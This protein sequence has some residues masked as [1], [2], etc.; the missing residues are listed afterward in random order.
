MHELKWRYVLQLLGL[1]WILPF[2]SYLNP[3]GE[4]MMIDVGQGDCFL[5]QL[6][7]HQGTMMIDVAGSLYKNIPETVIAPILKAKGIRSIDVLVVSH[8]DYDHSGGLNELSDLV[9][10][11]QVITD[12]QPEIALGPARFSI[13]QAMDITDDRNDQS[14]IVYG[15]LGRHDYL[16][17]GDAGVRVEEYLLSN[18]PLLT[19]DVLKLGH[20]GS[21]TSS[22]AAF[23]QQVS[24]QL[25][26]I[27]AGKNNRYHHPSDEVIKR[28][29][30][31][32]IA[33]QNS[34]ET[35]AVSIYVTP[36]FSFFVNASHEFGFL[37]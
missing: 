15:T 7:F 8:D 29:N 12:Y 14:L 23:L 35:G 28:L 32:Q 21:N 25:A 33:Y 20:H 6:P 9:S 26:L 31:Y 13:L 27:S 11:D 3:F 5:I 16:F 1:L 24:P 2:Q 22:S 34:A 17:M 36:W 4:V 19:C 10:I 18:Y 37:K 30:D